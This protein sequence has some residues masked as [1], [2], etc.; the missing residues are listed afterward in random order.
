ALANAGYCVYAL[1]YGVVPGEGFESNGEPLGGTA[2]IQVGAQELADFVDGV[3]SA[4]GTVEA[5]RGGIGD[6]TVDLL[7]HGE[8]ALVA[9]Y[10]AKV[11]GGAD[12]VHSIVSLAPTWA[13]AGGA[14]A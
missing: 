2:P 8:G 9:G 5:A 13:G 14:E 1:T 11:L 10:Y 3:Q 7:G 6:G 12:H 4:P